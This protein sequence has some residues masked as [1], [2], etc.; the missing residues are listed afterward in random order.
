MLV[1]LEIPT[2]LV[3]MLRIALTELSR[4][5]GNSVTH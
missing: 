2:A 1:S 4:R 5:Q 3:G